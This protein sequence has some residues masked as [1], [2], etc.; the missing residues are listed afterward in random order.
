[1]L[2]GLIWLGKETITGCCE[3][4]NEP[5]DFLQAFFFKDWFY[6]SEMNKCLHE[7]FH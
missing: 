2:T 1:M 6:C 3:L 4:G 7:I 5:L